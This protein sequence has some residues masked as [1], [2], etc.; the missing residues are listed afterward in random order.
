MK[1][2]SRHPVAYQILNYGLLTLLAIIIL[3]PF[4]YLVITS[5]KTFEESIAEFTW[6]PQQWSLRNFKEVLALPDFHLLNYFINTVMIFFL[7][8]AGTL[9][10]CTL[11]GYAFVRYHFK[12]KELIFSILMAV[13]LLPGELLTIPMY[14]AFLNLGW[15]DTFNPLVV[16][17]WFATDV[18]A[19]FLFRQFFLTVP[20]SLF[21]AA[22]I[23][24]ASEWRILW[25]I[26]VPLCKPVFVTLI[27]LYFTGTYNDIYGPTLY[28]VSDS[29]YTVA[30]GLGLIESLY[31]TGS[32]DFVVPLNLVGA[33]TLLS[34]VPVLL[35]FM[36]GQ[37]YFVEG[38]STTGL[39]G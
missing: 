21:E 38:I 2:S 26:M 39:K 25:Q 34:I 32:Q 7:K 8:T 33:A 31:S 16:P 5:F 1:S 28:L 37:R 17:A 15:I 36:V 22:R 10:T 18:F 4:Y 27:L 24:G 29:N 20:A 12:F 11:A 30:Q 6:V 9:F 23:D 14:E 19:I 3:L 13:L 35:F